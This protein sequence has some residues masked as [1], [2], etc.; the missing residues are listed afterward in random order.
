M[1]AT[2]LSLIKKYCGQDCA[3]AVWLH[4]AG[5]HLSVPANL[6]PEHI[7]ISQ[8]GIKNAYALSQAFGGETLYIAKVAIDKK[9]R[10]AQIAEKR[11]QGKSLTAIAREYDLSERQVINIINLYCADSQ[12]QSSLLDF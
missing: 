12:H 11:Q 5:V 8:L 1:T 3:N 6:K 4:Y 9:N 7:L 2:T 10:N